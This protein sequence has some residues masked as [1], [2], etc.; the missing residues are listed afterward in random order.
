MQ[1][2]QVRHQARAG[3]VPEDLKVFEERLS[4]LG[5]RVSLPSAGPADSLPP[6]EHIEGTP[7]SELIVQAR[8]GQ[9]A[10]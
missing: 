9:A 3:D 10:G 2:V 7:L 1:N 4:T 8:N 6:L 5:V